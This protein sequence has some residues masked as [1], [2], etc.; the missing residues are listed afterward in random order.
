MF[1][2]LYIPTFVRALMFLTAFLSFAQWVALAAYTDRWFML[3][4][5]QGLSMAACLVFAIVFLP[6][7]KKA[8]DGWFVTW[9]LLNTCALTASVMF[10]YPHLPLW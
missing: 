5:P 1:K 7:I 2:N 3:K 8:F 6:L 4:S 9:A 10:K